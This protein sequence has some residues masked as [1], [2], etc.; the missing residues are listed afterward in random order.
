M[1][2]SFFGLNIARSGLFA[3]QRALNVTGHNIAN[4]NT[5]GYSRQR[6]EIAPSNPMALPGGEGMMGTGVDTLH[7]KNIRD[8][9]LDIKYR[10]EN[11]AYGEWTTRADALK[12]LE[13]IF[14]EPSESG[15]RKV[16]NDYFVSLEKLSTGAENLTTR[17]TVR[18]SGIKLAQMVNQLG[19]QLEKVQEDLDFN[20]KTTVDQINGYADQVAKLN[21]QI[22][23]F[24]LDGSRAND[25]RDQRNL[26]LDKLSE[27]VKIDTFEEKSGKIRVMVDGNQ[28]V[29]KTGAS[30]L[31]IQQR[32]PGQKKNNSDV[33][34][35]CDVIWEDGA[36]FTPRGG[37]IKGYIDARDNISGDEKGIP[38]Y[39]DKLND[40]AKTF[41]VQTNLIHREGYGLNGQHG[42]DFFQ[43]DGEIKD[44]TNNAKF[45]ALI[46]Q[47]GE[48]EA[49]RMIEGAKS[50]DLGTPPFEFTADA[51][52]SYN[53]MSVV[54]I[55]EDGTEK[56]YITSKITAKSMGISDAVEKDLNAIAASSTHA[57]LPGSG[58]NALKM[59][60]LK[61]KADMYGWGKP[62][63]FM[64]SLISNLGVDSQ[65]AKN[66]S[67]NQK[68]LLDQTENKRQSISGVSLDEEMANLVKFQHAYQANARMITVIDEMIDTIINRM[69]V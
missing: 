16:M 53:E 66:V 9:F 12:N 56:Y 28:L 39:V 3:S 30:H 60:Q 64:K 62:E 40:F 46:H 22:S 24:E 41:V 50:S 44:I 59:N 13:A 55:V 31:K 26:V 65:H 5:P 49:I 32:E 25:L 54:K 8:D 7:I 23:R 37:K 36:S 15:I 17:A 14:G 4:V 19:Y 38:Y 47:H 20:V 48:Q 63:D 51:I 43:M 10:D 58:D 52:P 57:G 27:L 35:L 69:G 6:V 42:V 18:E 11:E 29:S 1:S 67:S 61:N 33:E 45:K 2:G 68:V 21:E 34:Q